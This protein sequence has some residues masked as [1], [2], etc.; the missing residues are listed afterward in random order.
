MPLLVVR[1]REALAADGAVV[2]CLL[3]VR[4]QVDLEVVVAGEGLGAE[5]AGELGGV[6]GGVG[7]EEGGGSGNSGEVA[8][9]RPWSSSRCFSRAFRVGKP[10][11][12]AL[13]VGSMQVKGRS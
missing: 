12:A 9:S 7:G 11:V 8:M 3:L 10:S 13:H 1:P 5:G 2:G 6:F 4:A